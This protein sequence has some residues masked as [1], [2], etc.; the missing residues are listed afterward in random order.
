MAFVIFLVRISQ[1]MSLPF[2]AIYLTRERLLTAGQIGFVLGISGFMFSVTSLINGIYVDRHSHKNTLI[3]TLFL[4]GFCYIGFAF[5][6]RTFYGL[7]ILSAALGWFRSLVEISAATILVNNTDSKDLSCALSARYIA[8][9]LG[10]VLGPLIGIMMTI[11]QSLFIFFTAGTINLCIGLAIL[12]FSYKKIKD[13][14]FIQSRDNVWEN[15][16]EL[17]KDRI[18]ITITL[19]NLILWIVYGQLDTT[20]PQYLAHHWK[21]STALFGILMIINGVISILFQS[22]ILRWAESTSLKI[23]GIFGSMMFTLSFFL[24]G[25]HPTPVFIIVS[26]ITMSLAE[27]LTLPIN[28][29]LIMSVAPKNLVAS[30]NGFI[31]LS[32]LGLSIGPVF[33]GYGLQFIGGQYVFLLDATLPIIAI[34]LYLKCPHKI[35]NCSTQCMRI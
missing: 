7:L 25:I 4:S 5:S 27:L 3:T 31:N 35:L 26:V 24:L 8:A 34:W 29:L 11:H 14:E 2:L 12:L 23:S 20:L 16:R 18:L 13:R 21:N 17:F 1:F 32:L 28:G 19:I 15:F 6:M 33:G 22:T 10:V 9:N 30:Y